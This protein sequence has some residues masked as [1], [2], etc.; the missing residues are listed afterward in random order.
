[1]GGQHYADWLSSTLWLYNATE[2]SWARVG[3]APLY[4]RGHV[5]GLHDGHLFMALGQQGQDNGQL[6]VPG[7]VSGRQFWT[8]LPPE[9]T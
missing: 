1:V 4:N 3:H 6:N 2:D 8:A 5:C 7:F 9:L